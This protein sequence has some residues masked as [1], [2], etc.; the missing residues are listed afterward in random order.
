MSFFRNLFSPRIPN[1]PY[2]ANQQAGVDSI[3]TLLGMFGQRQGLAADR[4]DMTTEQLF[5]EDMDRM[6]RS[7]SEGASGTRRAVTR[8]ALAG[9]GDASGSLAAS[10]L[11]IDQNTNRA[12]G[13][14]MGGFTQMAMGE[15]SRERSR[16]DALLGAMLS[17]EQGMLRR[18]D[19]RGDFERQLKIQQQQANRQFWLDLIGAGSNTATSAMQRP[20][21]P[22][23]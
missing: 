18:W 14:A 12:I 4:S 22:G 23:V 2:E 19:Q 13:D 7:I 21:P 9:G 11:S 1:N 17:G 10:L 5:G 15:R 20:T 6:R 16:A 3:N 8:S